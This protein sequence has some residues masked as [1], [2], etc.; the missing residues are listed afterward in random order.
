MVI[1]INKKKKIKNYNNIN[2]DNII[3][4]ENSKIFNSNSKIF[5]SNYNSS[6]NSNYDMFLS[7]SLIELWDNKYDERW[8]NY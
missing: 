7:K 6:N 1:K 4:N 8:N 2:Q 3:L 5:N